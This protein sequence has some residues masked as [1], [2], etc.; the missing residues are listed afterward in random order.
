MSDNGRSTPEWVPLRAYCLGLCGRNTN[1]DP[2][3]WMVVP[4][5]GDDGYWCESCWADREPGDQE[6]DAKLWVQPDW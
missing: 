4:V 3:S 5:E 6:P 2:G 1:S